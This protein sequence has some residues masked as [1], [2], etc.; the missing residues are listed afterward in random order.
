ML[1][2]DFYHCD[3]EALWK[4]WNVEVKRKQLT[5]KVQS[6]CLATLTAASAE[7]K[8]LVDPHNRS[9]NCPES[10]FIQ[11][12]IF[13]FLFWLS[14]A[15]LHIVFILKCL[16]C[17]INGK[18]KEPD[19]QKIVCSLQ[20]QARPCLHTYTNT[21]HQT[22]TVRYLYLSPMKASGA[23]R[24]LLFLSVPIQYLNSLSNWH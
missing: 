18:W 15:V 11:I 20:I 9:I 3:I 14:C 16:L 21:W 1:A 5:W 10:P 23:A 4:P 8:M 12:A 24:A 6:M 22:R 2:K 19:Q 7:L 13:F 17:K